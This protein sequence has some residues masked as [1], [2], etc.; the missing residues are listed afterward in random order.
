MNYKIFEN[1]IEIYNK[2]DFNAQH[3]IECGQIFTYDKFGDYYLVYSKDKKAKLIE[4]EDKYIIETNNTAYFENF[5]DLKTDYSAIKNQISDIN[6]NLQPALDYGFGIR[7][8]KQDIL[9]VTIG[10]IISANN[11]IS[12]IRNSMRYIRENAG[13]KIDDYFAFPSLESLA[14][15]DTDFFVKAGLG[16]RAS[17]IVKA[18]GQLQNV[19]FEKL[20]TLN[21]SMLRTELLKI[22]GVG[23]KVADCILLFGFYRQDVF[24]VDT[25]IEKIYHDMFE[26]TQN[27]REYMRNHLVEYFE[28][29][30]GYAQ[31][32]LFYFKRSS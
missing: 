18:I 16:Y 5:F 12:R 19:D 32:Y 30:S 21:T 11:N 26:K 2:N 6:K 31:Q 20:K 7:I 13:Q 14:K 17:Q 24:P 9:E 25:W 10:F 22:N 23:G 1:K 27:N 4:E 3:I 15:L 8:L 29:L 28:N